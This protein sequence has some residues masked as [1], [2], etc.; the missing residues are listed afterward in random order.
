[1]VLLSLFEYFCICSRYIGS[2][3]ALHCSIMRVARF[4]I[5]MG[6]FNCSFRNKRVTKYNSLSAARGALV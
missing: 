5:I 3:C 4:L 1:M 6:K 2:L